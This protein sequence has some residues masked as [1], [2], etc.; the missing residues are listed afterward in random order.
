MKTKKSGTYTLLPKEKFPREFYGPV[1]TNPRAVEHFGPPF[2]FPDYTIL[3]PGEIGPSGVRDKVVST[4]M[5]GQC[6]A[7][8][9]AINE[10]TGWPVVSAC[11]YEP[12]AETIELVADAWTHSLVRVPTKGYLDIRRLHPTWEDAQRGFQFEN[13]TLV[14]LP[15]EKTLEMLMQYIP[16]HHFGLVPDLEMARS[17]VDPLLKREG[18]WRKPK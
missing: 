12:A 10:R 2:G 7:L 11:K 1:E 13:P 5:N 18:L 14:V 16:E 6:H 9:L 3:S 4:Y 8:A 17:F 15:H